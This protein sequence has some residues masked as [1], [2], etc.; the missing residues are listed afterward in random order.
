[1]RAVLLTLL[2]LGCAGGPQTQYAGPSSPPSGFQVIGYVRSLRVGLAQRGRPGTVY[3]VGYTQEE[4][5]AHAAGSP[6]FKRAVYPH[7]FDG[8]T[9]ESEVLIRIRAGERCSP[10]M[11]RTICIYMLEFGWTWLEEGT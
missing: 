4:F 8:M 7:D 10:D 6:G 5:D 2:A 1:V 3:L 11:T 9:R